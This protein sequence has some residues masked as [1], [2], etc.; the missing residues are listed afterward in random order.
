QPRTEADLL[1]ELK[2]QCAA[3]GGDD[4]VAVNAYRRMP[5][6]VRR[7]LEAGLLHDQRI[8]PACYDPGRIARALDPGD[9]YFERAWPRTEQSL[10][11]LR[12]SVAADG[13]R[14]IVLLIPDACQIDAS[15]QQFAAEI[16]YQVDSSWLTHR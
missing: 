1:R 6:D 3:H 12:Q 16:G 2:R 13:A 10:E 9:D 5:E 4:E 15:A 7:D 11:L 14:L 8:L